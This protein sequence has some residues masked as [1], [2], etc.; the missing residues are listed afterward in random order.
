VGLQVVNLEVGVA[1]RLRLEVFALHTQAGGG[2][3][4]ANVL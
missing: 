2:V 4:L 3:R 1:H